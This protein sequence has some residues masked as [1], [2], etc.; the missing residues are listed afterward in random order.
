MNDKSPDVRYIVLH[1]PTPNWQ[2]GVDLRE[3]RG[4]MEHVDHYAQLLEDG[5]LAFG[6]P[7]LT[8]DRG[9]MMAP[10]AEMT[11]EEVEEYAAADPAVKSGLLSFEVAPWLLAMRAEG[12]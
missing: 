12:K 5:R 6:G 11:L 4:V 10:K 9:G 8:P 7:Y 3:Q 1:T 2:T